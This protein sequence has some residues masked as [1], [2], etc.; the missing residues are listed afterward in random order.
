MYRIDRGRVIWEALDGETLV[1]DTE[2]GFYFSLDEVGSVVWSLLATGYGEDEIIAA[3]R[4]DYEVEE[5][6]ARRD[7]RMLI[8]ELRAE[9][10][11][12]PA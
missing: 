11:I 1:V 3:V 2:S 9:Q 4:T 10:L 12:T 8:E 6:V 7:V 5:E